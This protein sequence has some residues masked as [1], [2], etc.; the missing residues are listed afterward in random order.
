[1]QSAAGPDADRG[2]PPPLAEAEADE[3]AGKPKE[4]LLVA[5]VRARK[6]QPEETDAEKHLKEEQDILRQI[7]TKQALKSVKELAKV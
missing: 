3:D 6:D 1:M 2:A 4:S 5:A 7:T